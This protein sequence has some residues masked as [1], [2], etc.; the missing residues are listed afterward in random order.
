ML[1][2][3]FDLNHY[4]HFVNQLKGLNGLGGGEEIL[5]S[6]H[7]CLL[8]PTEYK[9]PYEQG[10]KHE[11]YAVSKTGVIKTA[12]AEHSVAEGFYKW[13]KG[14]QGDPEPQLFAGDS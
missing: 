8:Y 7:K 10:Y 11:S 1:G 9:Q 12:Y 5:D 13:G 6:I 4:T 14:V 2:E 3:V